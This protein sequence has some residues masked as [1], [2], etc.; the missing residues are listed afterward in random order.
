MSVSRINTPRCAMATRVF[1]ILAQ[2]ATLD[3]T[4]L[5]ERIRLTTG[6]TPD[7]AQRAIAR[8]LFANALET[9]GGLKVQTIH[10]SFECGNGDREWLHRT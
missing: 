5:D 10:A 7:S 2:W 6:K 4:A 9:P 1:D 3:D 8:R